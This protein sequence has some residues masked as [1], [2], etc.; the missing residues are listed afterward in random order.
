MMVQPADMA[1]E[2]RMPSA[3]PPVPGDVAR[4]ATQ[5]CRRAE[6]HTDAWPCPSH[7]SEAARQLVRRPG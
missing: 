6:P 5:L 1:R 4:R 3:I 7:L 2:L